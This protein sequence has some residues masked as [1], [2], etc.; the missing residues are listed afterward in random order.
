M[1][2]ADPRNSLA[3]LSFSRLPSSETHTLPTFASDSGRRQ[4]DSNAGP[5]SWALLVLRLSD[6][7]HG[8]AGRGSAQPARARVKMSWN[9]M[10][11]WS[12][13]EAT[14]GAVGAVT[15]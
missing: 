2:F 7:Q 8:I 14:I 12:S 5:E 3:R 10:M 4:P 6:P 13:T 15:P 11:P 9:S 1:A